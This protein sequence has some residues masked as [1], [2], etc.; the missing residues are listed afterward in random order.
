MKAN[1]YIRCSII[2]SAII[3]FTA[4]SDYKDWNSVDENTDSNPAA[5]Q[6]LW[7]YI[8]S[9]DELSDFARVISR[10]GMSEQLS[11]SR[12]Y[13]IWAPVNGSFNVDSVLDCTDEAIT[14]QFLNHHIADYNHIAKV[15][16]KEIVNTLDKKAQLFVCDNG[17]FKFNDRELAMSDLN[18]PLYNIPATNGTLHMIKGNSIF[19]ANGME[20][21]KM[22][23]GIDKIAKYILSY[24][25][26]IL[27]TRN[28]VI[29]PVV[30][31]KQ[32]YLDSVF[33]VSNSLLTRLRAFISSEDS[34]YS[35][36]LPTDDAYTTYYDKVKTFYKYA[37]MKWQ[38]V[39]STDKA[40][41]YTE[42]TITPQFI[43]VT[44]EYLI[45]SL[46]KRQMID[47]L[48]YSNNNK[49]NMHLV[50]SE[51]PNYNDTIVTPTRKVFSNGNEIFD[52]EHT[53]DKIKL[54]NGYAFVTDNLAFTSWES[55]NPPIFING[56]SRCRVINY[57]ENK[58]VRLQKEDIN[59][60]L[61]ELEPG[62][63]YISYCWAKAAAKGKP[64]V[65]F[66]LYNVKATTYNVYCVIPPANIDKR[67]KTSEVLE[68]ILNFQYQGYYT[69]DKNK[70]VYG[71][72][73]FTNERYVPGSKVK[74]GTTALKNTDFINDIS[75]V[76]TMY[77]GQIKFPYSY[78]GLGYYPNIK[79]TSSARININLPKVL[80]NY[81]RDIRIMEIMLLTPEYEEHLKKIK[82][83]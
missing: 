72:F 23:N 35:V 74:G 33:T 30:N 5:T 71:S 77:L 21:L 2:A 7:E 28:S 12:Y 37:D 14:T 6:T 79:V 41:G 48:F 38:D 70:T 27:D 59:T 58:N 62:Q 76:D 50:N 82:N 25:D 17:I 60:D 15:N 81:T 29:G 47:Y 55:Y 73:D 61:I 18:E 8:S 34:T 68:N 22:I 69:N 44:Y 10:V 67:D 24:N 49:Y 19:L 78:Y 51:A 56:T 83:N 65:D 20:A 1:K 45:D 43:D 53:V 39:T 52:P 31:G 57:L 9:R 36:L 26:T 3:G 63:D 16:L 42:T 66:Y 4:C 54:S 75:K 64:E 80:A 11:S 13:T 40:S 32:T 46:T